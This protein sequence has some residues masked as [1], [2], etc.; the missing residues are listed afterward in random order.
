MPSH[1]TILQK[2]QNFP[3]WGYVDNAKIPRILQTA[4][5]TEAIAALAMVT[6]Y[7]LSKSVCHLL[8]G[9]GTMTKLTHRI[10]WKTVLKKL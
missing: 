1:N 5:T 4:Q 10:L 8:Q 6:Q 9:V 7:S 3:D 2:D